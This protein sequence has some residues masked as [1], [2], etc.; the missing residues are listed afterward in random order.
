MFKPGKLRAL[1]I[2]VMKESLNFKLNFSTHPIV[3]FVKEIQASSYNIS[4][5]SSLAW[6]MDIHT[7]TMD[8]V[9]NCEPSCVITF[10]RVV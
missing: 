6:D 8:P 10:H 1:S 5:V 2:K 7:V 3:M 9:H 4:M